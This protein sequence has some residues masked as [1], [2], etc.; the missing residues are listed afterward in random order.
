[1]QLK[2]SSS[3]KLLSIVETIV[4]MVSRMLKI[5]GKVK[6][7]PEVFIKSK[8]IVVDN[9]DDHLC[10]HRFLALCLYPELR[11]TK[12]SNIRH[13][14]QRAKSIFLAEHGITYSNHMTQA[15]RKHAAAILNDFQG[16]NQFEMKDA[17]INR[18]LKIN[19]FDYI[20]NIQPDSFEYITS[21]HFCLK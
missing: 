12:V 10:W 16:M 8:S 15:D 13:R 4:F 17:A 11:N 3:S 6:G 19:V 9:E 21:S 2:T 14:T 20:M 18:K 1:M 5:S 7:L